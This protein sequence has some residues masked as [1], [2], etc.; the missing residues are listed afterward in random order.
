[1]LHSDSCV[2]HLM[3]ALELSSIVL[4]IPNDAYTTLSRNMI[5]CSKLSQ[6]VLQVDCL[7]LESH[8]KSTLNINV[9]FSPLFS[10]IFFHVRGIF[11]S[12][13]SKIFSV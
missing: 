6:G 12:C 3:L 5:G 13:K 10:R 1:M 9:P 4:E 8:K 11:F 7:I 2:R